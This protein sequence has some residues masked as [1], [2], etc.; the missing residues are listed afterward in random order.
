MPEVMKPDTAVIVG[1][2][3]RLSRVLGLMYTAHER[4]TSV[5][6]RFRSWFYPDEFDPTRSDEVAGSDGD[7]PHAPWIVDSRLHLKVG[8]AP[9]RKFDIAILDESGPHGYAGAIEFVLLPMRYISDLDLIKVGET[10]IAGRQAIEIK[11]VAR[12]QHMSLSGRPLGI[13][14]DEHR[15][16]MD[17]ER[18]ILL[19]LRSFRRGRSASGDEVHWVRFDDQVTDEVAAR[20]EETSEVVRLLYCAKR[21]FSTVRLSTRSWYSKLDSEQPTRRD[22]E[23]HLW[24]ENSTRFRKEIYGPKGRQVHV[25]DGNVW[26]RLRTTNDVLTNA[27]PEDI[28]GFAS[29]S[30]HDHPSTPIYEDA[31]HAMVSQLHLDPSW[32]ISRMW[33]TPIERTMWLG[34]KVVKVRGEPVRPDGRWADNAEKLLWRDGDEYELLID[35]ERGT[36]LRMTCRLDGEETSVDE[37]TSIEFDCDLRDTL[38]TLVPEGDM[39]VMICQAK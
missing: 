8:S 25:V 22:K 3:A 13:G 9:N 6:V 14:P 10:N 26:W 39:R 27:P 1:G 12:K 24:V 35:T 34:R 2:C 11:A 18:G 32:L 16:V 4:F 33:L 30:F 29:V 5:E 19:S 15:L 23:T 21:S 7:A 38:F 31:E 36:L 37:V 17:S 28:R 20:F